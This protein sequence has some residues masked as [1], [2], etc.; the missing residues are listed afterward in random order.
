MTNISPT[1]HPADEK[2]K[3]TFCYV[4][5]VDILSQILRSIV[6]DQ[7]NLHQGTAVTH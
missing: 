1:A 5:F 7:K 3:K 6:T 2:E 4:K